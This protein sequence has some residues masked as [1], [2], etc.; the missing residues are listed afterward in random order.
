MQ[1]TL[2]KFNGKTPVRRRY[3]IPLG[4]NCCGL[5]EHRRADFWKLFS[6]FNNAR[7]F[8]RTCSALL[9]NNTKDWI[10]SLLGRFNSLSQVDGSVSAV[11]GL[12][13]ATPLSIW[14][15][16]SSQSQ[17]LLFVIKMQRSQFSLQGLFKSLCS[18]VDSN[19][20]TTPLSFHLNWRFLKYGSLVMDLD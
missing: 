8:S 12:W 7:G 9:T 3:F 15:F 19:T 5:S 10:Y 2:E 13:A 16:P 11:H 6:I 14:F 20:A 17:A 1:I 4:Y 18:G